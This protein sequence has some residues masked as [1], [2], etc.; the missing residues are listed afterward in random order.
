MEGKMADTEKFLAMHV[1]F[2]ESDEYEGKPLGEFL[3]HFL[4]QRRISGATLL[5]A[6]MGFGSRRHIHHPK[7]VGTLDEVPMAL[8]VVEREELLRPLL[9]EI[10]SYIGDHTAII[11]AVEKF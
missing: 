1:F 10:R 5:R 2:D 4:L 3:L 9:A 8:M 11:G 7:H 6:E